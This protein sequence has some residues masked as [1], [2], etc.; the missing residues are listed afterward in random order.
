MK[1]IFIFLLVIITSSLAAGDKTKSSNRVWAEVMF[2]GPYGHIAPYE[3]SSKG[4]IV[5]D[6]ANL[7]TLRKI[8]RARV[9]KKTDIILKNAS[10]LYRQ[11]GLEDYL[12]A[13]CK[14]NICPSTP[15]M[16]N[17]TSGKEL[18]NTVE[19]TIEE[20]LLNE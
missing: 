3:D 18:K 17:Y 5:E 10:R 4:S 1:S 2:G 9:S 7:P 16:P 12:I 20:E 11:P 6:I 13:F 14:T 19:F 8:K 15:P